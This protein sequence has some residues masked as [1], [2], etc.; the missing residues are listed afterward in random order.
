M[1]LE[2]ISAVYGSLRNG[3]TDVTDIV[4]SYIKDDSL[5]LYVSNAIF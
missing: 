3:S 2:I 5:N 1:S 4:K